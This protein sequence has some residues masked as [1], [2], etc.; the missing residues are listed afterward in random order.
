[1]PDINDKNT[2][3]T[4]LHDAIMEA[5][6]DKANTA[7]LLLKKYEE[8]YVE[9]E[10]QML[11]SVE[12]TEE[13]P[14]EVKEVVKDPEVADLVKQFKKQ[15]V[16]PTVE[17]SLVDLDE[18]IEQPELEVSDKQEKLDGLK[19]VSAKLIATDSKESMA[20]VQEVGVKMKEL[21]EDIKLDQDIKTK[22]KFIRIVCR[23]H[24]YEDGDRIKLVLNKATIHPNITLRNSGYTIDIKLKEGLN[25]VEFYAL[26]EGSSGPNTAELKVI[27]EGG[28][29]ISSG[30]WLLTTGYKARLIVL[31]Q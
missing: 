13:L 21:E 14:E 26:N 4:I 25:T 8:E 16:K 24:E 1:M 18:I 10:V 27:D 17:K 31:K 29:V 6:E 23:D 11:D 20:I 7:L 19:E 2:I 5:D 15:E 9:E 22:S 30:Q 28:S 12:D 3:M